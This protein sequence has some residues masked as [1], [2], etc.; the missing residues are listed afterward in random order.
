MI[1][2]NEFII[3]GAPEVSI[4]TSNYL[5]Q[6]NEKLTLKCIVKSLVPVYIKWFYKNNVIKVLHSRQAKKI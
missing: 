2:N 3:T 1:D 6:R 4:T 5:I